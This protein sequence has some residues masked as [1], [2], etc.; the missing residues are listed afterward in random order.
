MIEK[1]PW[2][3]VTYM[4]KSKFLSVAQN[5]SMLHLLLV[6]STLLHSYTKL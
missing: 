4:I 5:G 1:L 2:P 3:A 6:S